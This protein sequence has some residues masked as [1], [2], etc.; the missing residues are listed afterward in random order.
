MARPH[1]LKDGR[2]ECQNCLGKFS[3]KPG[4]YIDPMFC[5]NS[6]RYQFHSTGGMSLKRFESKVQKWAEKFIAEAAAPVFAA[7]DKLRGE[8]EAHKTEGHAKKRNPVGPA[9][10]SA[11]AQSSGRR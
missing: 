6:C 2:F 3:K 10:S 7:L 9:V 5:S 4:C 11:G 8:L 1:K